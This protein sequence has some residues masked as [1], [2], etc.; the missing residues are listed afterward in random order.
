[1]SFK[2]I[3]EGLGFNSVVQHLPSK[4]KAL[5]LVPN[6][7]KKEKRRKKSLKTEYIIT[8]AYYVFLKFRRID[9]SN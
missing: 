7:Q 5:G 3:H 8:I 6:P 2:R 4:H 9:G 1:L